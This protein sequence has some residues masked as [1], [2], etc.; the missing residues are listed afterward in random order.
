MNR[1]QLRTDY[2]KKK[3]LSVKIICFVFLYH[4]RDNME[5][6]LNEVKTRTSSARLFSVVSAIFEIN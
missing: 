4:D 1:M 6:H 5:N 2:K 3:I